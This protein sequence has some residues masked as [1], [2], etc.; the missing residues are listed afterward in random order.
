MEKTKLRSWAMSI[1]SGRSAV[2]TTKS[3]TFLVRVGK[4]D[5]DRYSIEEL[6]EAYVEL[7]RDYFQKPDDIIDRPVQCSCQTKPFEPP[8]RLVDVFWFENAEGQRVHKEHKDAIKKS[9]SGKFQCWGVEGNLTA[10]IV[11]FEDGTVELVHPHCIK[12]QKGA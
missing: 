8:T 7:C 3:N 6:A 5:F 10:A 4:S 12:F 2:S 11:E 1:A 9:R